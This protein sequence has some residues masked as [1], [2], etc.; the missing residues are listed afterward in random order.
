MIDSRFVWDDDTLTIDQAEKAAVLVALNKRLVR[1]SP[2]AEQARRQMESDLAHFLAAA[3]KQTAA[4]IRSHAKLA[5][6]AADQLIASLPDIQWDKLVPDLQRSLQA[7]ARDASGRAVAQLSVHD[8]A[9][10]DAA[11]TVASGWAKKRAAE[12]VGRKWVAG[13]LVPNPDAKWTISD[14]T[15]NEIRRLVTHAYEREADIRDLA[16]AVQNSGAFSPA[17]AGTIARTEAIGAENKGNLTGW[18]QTDLV[19]QVDVQTSEDHDDN[20]ECDCSDV[21]DAG[22]YPVDQAPDLPRHPECMCAYR[23]SGLAGEEPVEDT[24]EID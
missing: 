8:G 20:A 24:E 7:I 4:A 17:R 12:M 11:N 9:V 5:K 23:I 22:P 15:R 14:T 2:V 18:Q 16:V 1:S 6:G 13:R 3:G 21:E 10:L 19:D